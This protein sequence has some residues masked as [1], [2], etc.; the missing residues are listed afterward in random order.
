MA[1]GDA[2]QET[3]WHYLYRVLREAPR[4]TVDP[5]GL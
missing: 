3:R 1:H 2:R 4:E 5:Q